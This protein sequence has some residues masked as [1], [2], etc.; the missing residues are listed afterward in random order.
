VKRWAEI[1]ALAAGQ[2]GVVTR[3]Q[4]L[5][6]GLSAA[7]V[8]R[9]VKAGRLRPLHA[10]VYLVGPIESERAVEMAAVLAGGPSATLSHTSA[11]RLY[12]LL[13]LEPLRPVHVSVSGSGRGRRH[14]IVFHRV[15]HLADDEW[16][17]VDGIRVTS[18]GRTLVDA[19]GMLGSHEVELAVAAAERERLITG[20]ELSALLER[21]PRRPG[22]AVLRAV[23]REQAGPHFTRSE[24]E[25]R[26]RE[27]L[28][29]AGLPAPHANVAIGPYELDLFWPEENV[30]IEIDGW[31]FHSSRPRFEGDRRKDNWLRARGIEVIRLTWRQL[32]RDAIAT[33]V[34]VGQ[35]LALAGRQ[36]PPIA[37]KGTPPRTPPACSA[38]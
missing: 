14:G 11:V 18:P 32:T 25:R 15:D 3:R 24:A 36:R 20:A 31:Q 30:A 8:G 29:T 5:E 4:L 34:I 12:Q 21:Y 2:H 9:H 33:A 37:A 22:M 7:A 26:C 19:A 38:S 28:R 13:R 1:R 17:V 27:L 23:L 16:M 35:T 6:L 10:G